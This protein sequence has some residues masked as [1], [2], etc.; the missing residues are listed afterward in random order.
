[1]NGSRLGA[2]ETVVMKRIIT[3][4][5]VNDGDECTPFNMARED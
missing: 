4:H 2:A 3:E 5:E 1:M